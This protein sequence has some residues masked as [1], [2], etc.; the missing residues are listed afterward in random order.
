MTTSRGTEVPPD[1]I[2]LKPKARRDAV[3]RV[4]RGAKHSLM[5]SLFRC[6]DLRVIDELAYACRR[7]VRVRVLRTPRAKGWKQKL[8]ELESFL[9][10]L[11]AHVTRYPTFGLKY[12][13]KYIVADDDTALVTSLNFTRKCFTRTCDFVLVTHDREVISS[14]SA[15]FESDCRD[16]SSELPPGLSERLIV[17]PDISRRRMTELLRGARRSIKII[18]HRVVDPAMVQL[19]REREAEGIHVEILGRGE[20][21]GWLSHGK[22]SIIDGH[23]AVVGSIALSKPSLDFRREVAL[24]VRDPEVISRLNHF[25]NKAAARELIH[26]AGSLQPGGPAPVPAT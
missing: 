20:V 4:L 11:G 14:L 12:H 15:L 13:A 1:E 5:I 19:L 26:D 18:D 2:T 10:S 3:V 23:T 8:K 7:G 9:S 24:V 21:R 17:G 16:A 6:D 22:I 25:F